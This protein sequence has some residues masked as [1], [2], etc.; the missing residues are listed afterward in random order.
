MDTFLLT[1]LPGLKSDFETV[2]AAVR[3]THG[4]VPVIHGGDPT[5]KRFSMIAKIGTKVQ[6]VDGVITSLVTL[7]HSILRVTFDPLWINDE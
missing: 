5:V 4:H 3:Y 1:N 2:V 7:T 6:S